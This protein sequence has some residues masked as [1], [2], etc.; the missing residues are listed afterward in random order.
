LIVYVDATVLVTLIKHED[1]S[2]SVIEYLDDLAE[3]DHPL[4]AGQLVETELRRVA[5]RFSVD[6]SSVQPVLE[7]VNLVDQ[8]PADFRQAG[9]LQ[10][11]HLG[12]LDA[13]HL[14]TA[15]RT[16]AT[17]MLT[18]NQ[19]LAEASEALGIRV[20]DVFIPRTLISGPHG[21]IST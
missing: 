8:T 13:L 7:R 3:D 19:R 9:I 16:Q 2:D 20:L 6:Q 10:S 18:F 1:S 4:V 5:N 14:A 11:R 12:T 21:R 15:I 17:T